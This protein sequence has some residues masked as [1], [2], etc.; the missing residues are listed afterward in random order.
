MCF[1]IYRTFQYEL[2]SFQDLDSHVRHAAAV[3]E[4]TGLEHI[5]VNT[6][7]KH[8]GAERIW[9][10][11]VFKETLERNQTLYYNDN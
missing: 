11:N 9:L 4:S 10:K 7:F 6:S 3:S 1:Y 2:A 8:L 5:W